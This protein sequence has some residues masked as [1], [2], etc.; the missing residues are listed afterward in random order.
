MGNYNSRPI[1]FRQS[2]ADFPLIVTL[3]EKAPAFGLSRWGGNA[4]LRFIPHDD[5][6]YLLRGNKQRLV[7]KGQRRSHRLTIL[8]DSAFE[9]DCILE[10]EPDSNVVSLFMEGAESFDFFRQPDFVPDPFLKGSFAVYKKDTFLGE[11]TGKLCHIHRPEIIDARERRCWGELSIVGNRLCITIPEQWLADAAYPVIVDPTI[12]TTTVGSQTHWRQAP[13]EPLTPMQFEAQI[14]VNRFLVS[15]TINGLCSGFIHAHNDYGEEA[16][17]R[18]L[19]YSES[20]TRPQNKLTVNEHF[21]DLRVGG[22]RPPAGWRLGMFSTNGSIPAGSHIW[23]GITTDFFWFPRFD[24]GVTC[25]CAGW[26]HLPNNL[27][28]TYPSSWYNINTKLSMYFTYS[29]SQ[30]YVRTITQGVTLTDSR[31]LAANYKRSTTQTV[32]ISTTFNG[33][34]TV[35]RKLQEAVRGFDNNSFNILF[36]RSIKETTSVS[37]TFRHWRIFFRGLIDNAGI[38]SEVNQGKYYFLTLTETVQ[39]AGY[40]FRGMLLFVS[41]FTRVFIRDY[42]LARFLRARQELV[43][44]SCVSREILLESRIG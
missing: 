20:A 24:F 33:L 31:K 13:G 23:F 29:S 44:K 30:N 6:G 40:V 27:P 41:I 3:A 10:R 11:G 35:Y 14:P 4:G 9:Y 37:D 7:Y 43:L 1:K 34:R 8:G 21:I 42:L 2:L 38:E 25:Y 19:I 28:N 5:E 18:A 12:G 26:D 22:G 15:E 39:A 17:G 36:M 16:G 32:R